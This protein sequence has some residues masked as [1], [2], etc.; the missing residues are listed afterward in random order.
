MVFGCDQAGLVA[1]AAL[2][3]NDAFL[4]VRLG[5]QQGARDL[6]GAETADRPQGQGK[7]RLDRHPLVAAKKQQSQRFVADLFDKHRIVA[8][9]GLDSLLIRDPRQETRL[10]TLAAEQV[11][12]LIPRGSIEPAGG[13]VGNPFPSPGL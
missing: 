6:G 5:R 4:H 13:V 10:N 9:G 3:A 11:D 12:R 2:G 7:P 8:G 1:Q